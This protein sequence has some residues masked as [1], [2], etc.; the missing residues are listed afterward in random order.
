MSCVPII[1]PAYEPD[2]RMVTLFEG[3][4]AAHMGPYVVVDDGSGTSYASIFEQVRSLVAN[5]G[6]VLVHE[7]NRGKGAALKTAFSHVL[8]HFPDAIGVVTADS[9]GQHVPD[10]IARVRQALEDDPDALVMG[11][12]TFDGDDV[13]WKSRMGNHIT[14]RV[15]GALTGLKVS[16]TQTG[17]RGIS[18][19]LMKDCLDLPGDRFEFETQ[20]LTCAHETTHVVEVPIKTIYD[21]KENHQ[22]HFNAVKDSWRIYRSLLRQPLTYAISSL[23]CSVTD[24]GAFALLCAGLRGIGGYVAIS[25]VLARLASGTLNYVLNSRLV[26]RSKK[27]DTVSAPRYVALALIIMALSASL[28]TIGTVLLPIVPEVVVKVFVDVFLFILSYV[29]QRQFVF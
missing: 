24:V 25:T 11:V 9:D 6:T 5:D 26:F 28:T 17:L 7:T 22:T 10:C 21:S 19:A 23:T 4:T 12:R 1:I 13:P 16:D 15:F 14:S 18:R 2:E 27:K 3:L 29:V 20:M 8:E